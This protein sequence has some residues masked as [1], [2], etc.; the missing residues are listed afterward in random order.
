M[1]AAAIG[2]DRDHPRVC[3]EHTL[4]GSPRSTWRGSSPRMRGTPKATIFY[5]RTAGIIPAYAGNTN[6]QGIGIAQ[7]RDHPRV[8]GEHRRFPQHCPYR[9]G[10]SPRM[11]GTRRPLAGQNKSTGI[12]PA[13]AGNTLDLLRPYSTTRDH[14][15]VCGE[16][17][18]IEYARCFRT[19]SSPRMRGT[20]RAVF[21][22]YNGVWIIP[23]YAGNTTVV[24]S[25]SSSPVG[26]SP[27][28]RGTPAAHGQNYPILRI[29]PAYAGN[30]NVNTFVDDQ[31]RDHPRVCGEHW[32]SVALLA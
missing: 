26:S 27:R 12:I 28:M 22:R 15:R 10:S 23:A 9:W 25:T 4:T 21:V 18:C 20:P 2:T 32:L 30:T 6:L 24:L 7:W 14:P 16:H 11:R 29:I 19:G 5:H 13:Y 31:A 8:C 17:V 3:G 1:C